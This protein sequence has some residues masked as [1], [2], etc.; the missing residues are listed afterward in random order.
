MRKI[1]ASTLIGATM[2][3][4]VVAGAATAFA[5]PNSLA[6][7]DTAAVGQHAQPVG[8]FMQAPTPELHD[9]RT[10]FAIVGALL[11][12]ATGSAVGGPVIAIPGAGLGALTGWGIGAGTEPSAA[13]HR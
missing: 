2:T 11:G 7:P 10:L 3:T 5:S 13:A 6:T 9:R 8:D 4:G 1:L 12:G